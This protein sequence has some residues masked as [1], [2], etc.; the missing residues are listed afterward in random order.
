MWSAWITLTL[1]NT[2]SQNGAWL[3]KTKLSGKIKIM[4]SI[5]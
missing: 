4:S 2:P 5:F 3:V 1:D